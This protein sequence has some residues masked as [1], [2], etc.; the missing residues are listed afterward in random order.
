[1]EILCVLIGIFVGI[2]SA[3]Y[4]FIKPLAERDNTI[5]EQKEE[6][7]KVCSENGALREKIDDISFELST[8]YKENELKDKQIECIKTILEQND[9]GR[10][11]KK[12]EKLKELVDDYQSKN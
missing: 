8:A 2:A 4:M 11:E 9:Y 5:A 3:G 12:L 7:L 10:P 6:N 1:M